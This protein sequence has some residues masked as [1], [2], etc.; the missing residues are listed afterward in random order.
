M[1]SNSSMS[2]YEDEAIERAVKHRGG[3]RFFANYQRSPWRERWETD[4]KRFKSAVGA[5]LTSYRYRGSSA[6]VLSECP[7]C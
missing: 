2:Y 7:Y 3:A 1:S 4:N 5:T 6:P